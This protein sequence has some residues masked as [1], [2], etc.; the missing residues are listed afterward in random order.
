M[1]LPCAL[2]LPY[3][4]QLVYTFRF[5]RSDTKVLTD[6]DEVS[7]E[8]LHPDLT[9]IVVPDGDGQI[10]R[11]SEGVFQFVYDTPLTEAGEW[12]VA[13]IGTGNFEARIEAGF[14]VAASLFP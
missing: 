6:P 1:A 9:V 5:K 13:G 10:V 3:G 8:V 2:E 7:V 11:L 14:E 4:A 12:A